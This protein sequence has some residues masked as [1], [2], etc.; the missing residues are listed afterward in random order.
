MPVEHAVTFEPTEDREANFNGHKGNKIRLPK[1]FTDHAIVHEFGHMLEQCKPGIGDMA[2]EFREYRTEGCDKVDL[3]LFNPERRGEKGI[4]DH[5]DRYFEPGFAAY[6]GKEYTGG[7]TEILSMGL[8]A[9]HR[10]PYQF[11]KQDPEFFQFI[12]SCLLS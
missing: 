12:I 4:I 3:G 7:D 1:F 10:E 11:A 6:C 8:E 5:F 9:M 2:R